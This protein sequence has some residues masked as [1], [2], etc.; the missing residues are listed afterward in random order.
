MKPRRTLVIAEAGVNHNGSLAMAL[1]LVDAAAA[2]GADI[3]KFQT[4]K[5]ENLAS[6]SAPKALYQVETTGSDESQLDMLRRLELTPVAHHKIIARCKKRGI[7]F[8]STPFD[9]ESL[10][11]LTTELR[12]ARIKLP[13]GELTNPLLLLP[14]ARTRRP[15]ILSTGMADLKE[16]ELALGVLAY[17]YLRL[18]QKPSRRAF[19]TA[20][21]NARGQAMLK[22]NVTLLHCTTAYPAPVAD[23]NLLAMDTMVRRFGLSVGYSDHTLGTAV[24]VAAVARGA[25]VIEKHLTLDRTL[26][27]PDHRASLEPAE[28]KAMVAGIRDTERA[29]G[30]GRKMCRKSEAKNRPVARKSL[31]AAR[32]IARNE[33]F[34]E[35]N[36]TAKR[37]AQGRSVFDYWNILG[38]RA[39]RP[40]KR[41][42]R[43]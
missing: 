3:V 22:K 13:S 38:T 12:L 20:Y 35:D 8:L 40:Y 39:K 37:P 17:G 6:A 32:D 25:T 24:A 43:L 7:E 14:A 15:L 9:T 5:A 42:D 2:A 28:F 19:R 41:N 23:V 34:S 29:M 11:F 33:L 21:A 26:P 4:F 31:V 1:K 30:D 18:K 10:A 27:G 16:I 36:V